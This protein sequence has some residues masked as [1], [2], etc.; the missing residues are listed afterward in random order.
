MAYRGGRALS[1]ALPLHQGTDTPTE[2]GRAWL[3]RSL[4][5]AETVLV[6]VVGIAGTWAPII[7][8]LHLTGIL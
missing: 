6:W 5:L 7:L 2:W 4:G 1:A 3:E 8:A